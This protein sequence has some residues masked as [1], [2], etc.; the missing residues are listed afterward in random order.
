MTGS[1]VSVCTESGRSIAL[2]PVVESCPDISCM[3]VVLF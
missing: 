3:G 1:K 2:L